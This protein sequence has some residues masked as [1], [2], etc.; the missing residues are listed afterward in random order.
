MLKILLVFIVGL[1]EQVL[2]T[3]YLISVDKRQTNLSSI[4]M[5]AY[6]CLY[7]FVI[8][9]ALKDSEAVTLLIAYAAS[10]GLGNYLVMLWEK[11]KE[12]K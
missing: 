11:Y 12:K 7:L 4:L 6:M 5:F 8:A 2:Y 1:I 9:Y 3:M 10:C